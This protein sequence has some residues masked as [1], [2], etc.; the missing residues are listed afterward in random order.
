MREG[1]ALERKMVC[2]RRWYILGWADGDQGCTLALPDEHQNEIQENQIAVVGATEALEAHALRHDC[3]GENKDNRLAEIGEDIP[4]FMHTV[5]GEKGPGEGE[6]ARKAEEGALCTTTGW[7]VGTELKEI[8]TSEHVAAGAVPVLDLG[9]DACLAI[10]DKAGPEGDNGKHARHLAEVL[11]NV[12][13]KIGAIAAQG[14]G[15]EGPAW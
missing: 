6:D 12:E 4:E 9:A 7:R 2:K 3:A 10:P 14:R 1:G 13:Q 8:G 5:S 11:C 15:R